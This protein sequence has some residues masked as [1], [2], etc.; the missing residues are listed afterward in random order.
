M[1]AALIT[2]I[3]LPA[4]VGAA[5]ATAGRFAERIA[6]PVSLFTAAVMAIAATIAAITGAEVTG[7]VPAMLG[8]PGPDLRVD[9]LAAVVLPTVVWI[10]FLVLVFATADRTRP[11]AR[12]HGLMLL[13]LAAVVVTVTATGLPLLLAAWEVM[14]ATSY[15]LIGFR[16]QDRNRVAGGF[17]AFT[18]TRAGDLGLYLAAGAVVA[19]GGSWSLTALQSLPGPWVH[20]AAAGL[21]AAGFGKAAQLP[22]SFWISRAM[23][24]PSAVS[25]LLH[26]AAMVAMGG[27]LLLRVEPLLN[28][29]GWAGPTAAWLGVTTA[30][31]LGVIALSQRDVKQ[32]LAAS[33]AS[34]LGF[35]VLAAGVGSVSGGTAQLVAH[36][37]TKALLFLTAGAWLT[38]TGTKQFTGL[39]GVA[40]RWP[41]VGV[42][43]TV[44]A[45]SLAGLPPLSLWYAKDVVLAAAL[46]EEPWLYA[47]GLAGAALAAAYSARI[48]ALLWRRAGTPEASWDD[49]ERGTRRVPRLAVVPMVVLAVAAA[50][51]ALL[52]TPL[53]H[54]MLA[55]LSGTSVSW[56]ELA[57]SGAIAVVVV[58]LTLWRTPTV[59][60]GMH[61]FGLERAAVAVIATPTLRLAAAL[62]R[63]DDRYGTA[64]DRSGRALEQ[65]ARA[66]RALDQRGPAAVTGWIGSAVAVL[67]RL[68]RRPQTGQVHHYYIGATVTVAAAAVLLLVVR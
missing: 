19:G 32:V 8:A 39:R 30:I 41:A 52:G 53:L 60:S 68:A 36:A 20:V 17:T 42:L 10:G 28:V 67:G 62:A 27:Y 31:V 33:T 25:A 48:I 9:A 24:G 37:A 54:P 26:S 15:A 35:V 56:P 44:G 18:V 46:E 50:G 23:E 12:F 38:A 45:L 5:L 11:A 21:L 47:A 6:V 4:L 13:F 34:Q 66:A 57:A 61:W 22:F 29:T 3:I 55:P 49:E 64:V 16:W 14:G 65:T 2:A 7:G 63:L 51:L 1:S 58:L 40:A 43:A 59:R